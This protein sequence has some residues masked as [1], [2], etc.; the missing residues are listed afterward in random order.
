MRDV[1]IEA[2]N[3]EFN[4]EQLCEMECY[5]A[6]AHA[7]MIIKHSKISDRVQQIL[8]RPVFWSTADSYRFARDS[9]VLAS[10][11][12][13]PMFARRDRDLRRIRWATAIS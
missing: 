4:E 5:Q 1:P 10:C 7:A 13:W 6:Y 11:Q 3:V 9:G 12:Q 2:P 8:R